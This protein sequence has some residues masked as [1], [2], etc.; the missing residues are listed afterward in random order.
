MKKL[1][2]ALISTLFIGCTNVQH[3]RKDNYYSYDW[4]VSG[5]VGGK[6]DEAFRHHPIYAHIKDLSVE[7]PATR[8]RNLNYFFFGFFPFRH[9]VKLSELCGTDKFRQAY[10]S[11]NLWQGLVSIFTIGIYTPRTL[12][13]WCGDEKKTS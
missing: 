10:V 3:I 12:K 1:K 13:I 6:S 8:E 7:G 9:E 4:G 5:M 11:N 2:L